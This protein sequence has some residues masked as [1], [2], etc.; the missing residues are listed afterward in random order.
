[1]NNLKELAA[2]SGLMLLAGGIAGYALEKKIATPKDQ[3][4]ARK[5]AKR[6]KR[7]LKR[8]LKRAKRLA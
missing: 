8:E 7:K 4:V 1:M 5:Q 6:L 3:K 2:L